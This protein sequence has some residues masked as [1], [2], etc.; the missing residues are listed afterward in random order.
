M[1]KAI[2]LSNEIQQMNINI[3]CVDE[4]KMIEGIDNALK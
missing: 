4:Q 3:I 1:Q 2:D